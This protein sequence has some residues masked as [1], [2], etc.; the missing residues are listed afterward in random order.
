MEQAIKRKK[1]KCAMLNVV[2]LQRMTEL[3][4]RDYIMWLEDRVKEMRDIY[5]KPLPTKEYADNYT[6]RFIK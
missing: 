1:V 4:L 6:A 2:G 5:N 3:E